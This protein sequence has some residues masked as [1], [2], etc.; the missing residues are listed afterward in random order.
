MTR[1]AAVAGIAA[2]GAA[3]ARA[4]PLHDVTYLQDFDELWRTLDERYCF[5]AEKRTAWRRV[6][7]LSRPQAGLAQDDGA[8][9]DV[10]RRVLAELYDAHTHLSDPPDGTP[11]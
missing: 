4:E 10:V 11:R 8:F 7:T 9:L 6:R 2:L 1:R 5:F 3:A